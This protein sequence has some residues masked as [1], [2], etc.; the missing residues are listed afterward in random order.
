MRII[1][2]PL[3]L[4]EMLRS[5][6]FYDRRSPRLGDQFLD[7]VAHSLQRLKAMPNATPEISHGL[8]SRWVDRFPFSIV[9]KPTDAEAYIVA[10]A[11]HARRPGYWRRRLKKEDN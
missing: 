2:H 4:R 1:F 8:R 3:A 10:V 9:Y 11:H 5:A 7:E 6:A